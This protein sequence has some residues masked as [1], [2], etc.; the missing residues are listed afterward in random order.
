[1][2]CTVHAERVCTAIIISAVFA[3]DLGQFP[4]SPHIVRDLNGA[5][6]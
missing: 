5:G 3:G 4:I 6:V 2:P 1:V